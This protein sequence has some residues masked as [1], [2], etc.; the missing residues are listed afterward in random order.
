M[1]KAIVWL[2]LNIVVLSFG[3]AGYAQNEAEGKKL[4]TS[5]C[6]GCHGDKGKGDGP[7]ANALPVKPA[8]HSDGTVMN[9]LPDGFLIEII[10]KGGCGGRE[11]ADYAGMG[12]P[13]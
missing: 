12:K 7:A 9:Q 1:L 10:S 3:A 2:S 5:Y 6:A 11:V 13:I 8:N 4:Y